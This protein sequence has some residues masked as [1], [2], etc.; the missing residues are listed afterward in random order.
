MYYFIGIK[1]SNKAKNDI[2]ELM[3]RKGFRDAS[4]KFS[5]EGMINRYMHKLFSMAK[6]FFTLKKGDVLLIQYPFKKF[7]VCQCAISHM[8]GARTVTLIHDLGTFRRHKLTAS[9]EIAKLSH[10]DYI[11]VHNPCM[12]K[13]IKDNGCEIPMGSLDIFDYLSDSQPHDYEIEWPY[14]HIIYAGGFGQRKNAFIYSLD[15]LIAGCKVDLYG[16]GKLEISS[17]WHN[18]NFYGPKQSDKFIAEI[19]GHWGLVW[20]GDST[21]ECSGN[22]GEYLRIN[23]PHKASFYLRAGLPVIVWSESAM[24]SFVKEQEIGI[25][26]SALSQL[27]EVL[28]GISKEEYMRLRS[29]ALQMK[30]KLQKGYYFNKSFDEALKVI[31]EK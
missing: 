14:N 27:P 6:L 20:D 3:L 28:S 16:K 24:A 1:S 17:E 11:I 5:Q 7:Y 4:V 19:E 10:T 18:I 30:D 2:D 13:W 29:N 26:I 22:W 9:Q 15:S 12:M 21:E 23:N 25:C 31:A 8:K